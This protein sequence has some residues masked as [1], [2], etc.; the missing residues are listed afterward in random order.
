MQP[1]LLHAPFTLSPE[2][3]HTWFP[4]FFFALMALLPRLLA[5]VFKAPRR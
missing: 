4:V 3:L 1:L 2:S 5:W